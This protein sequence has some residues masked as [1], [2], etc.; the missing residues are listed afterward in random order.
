MPEFVPTPEQAAV[1]DAHTRHQ[2]VIVEAYAGCSKSTTLQ[3][4]AQRVMAPALALAFNK[5]I[6]DE[7]RPR[8]PANFVVRTLNGLGHHAWVL[9]IPAT[10]A[11]RLDERKLG[12][13]VTQVARDRKLDLAGPQWDQIRQL[14]SAAQQSGMVPRN[15]GQPMVMDTPEAW[16][17]LTSAGKSGFTSN[18]VWIDPDD[19]DLLVDLAKDVLVESNRLARQGTISF[20]DQVYCP[21]VLGGAWPQFPRVFVDESQDLSPLNHEMIARSARADAAI[22]AVGDTR[23]A[24]YQFRGADSQSMNSM[25][26]LSPQWLDLGLTTTFRCPQAIVARQQEH[27]PGFTAW[28]TNAPGAV[29]HLGNQHEGDYWDWPRLQRLLP[30]PGATAAVLCRNNAPLMSL[31]FKL[32]RAGVGPTMLGRDL[33]KG[34]VQLVTKLA[35]EAATPIDVVA[36]KLLEWQQREEALAR[37]NTASEA[38][39]D[40]ISDRAECIRATMEDTECRTAGEL[41]AMLA[42]LFT[43]TGGQVTLGS[44]HR[45]KGLEWDLVVHLDSWRIPSYQAK[46][47]AKLGD[48]SQL[49]QELNL[50]YV[51]ETRTRDVLVLASLADWS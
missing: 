28:H 44:I 45:S 6:A 8:L 1:A 5:K 35:P 20:D 29:Y 13:L 32:I 37:A 30:R 14:V 34:L 39:L 2:S 10:S 12:K 19:L 21:V 51:A 22:T 49:E 15:E 46:A 31:A 42:A 26:R 36:G 38:K 18:L 24:I 33:G 4:A 47:A 40:S 23:Q 25:R 48:R 27:A 7:L 16:A 9:T 11:I 17:N 50:R 3:L 41:R 43:R